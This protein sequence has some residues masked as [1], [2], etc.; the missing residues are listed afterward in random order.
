MGVGRGFPRHNPIAF[1]YGNHV[2]RHL[3]LA[4]SFFDL[5]ATRG[6]RGVGIGVIEICLVHSYRDAFF[7]CVIW[8]FCREDAV[9]SNN[10]TVLQSSISVCHFTRS[11]QSHLHSIYGLGDHSCH[12]LNCGWARRVRT[13]C[14][15]GIRVDISVE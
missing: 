1:G 11:P 5:Q 14:D 13:K 8:K 15:G 9:S 4:P 6:S 12:I 7:K 10:H 2:I 3:C